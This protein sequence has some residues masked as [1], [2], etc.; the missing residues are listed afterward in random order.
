MK[1]NLNLRLC[2]FAALLAALSIILGKVLA[3]RIGTSIRISFESLP[4]ILSGVFLGPVYGFFSGLVADIIG[5]LI[6]GY[7]I[8]PIITLGCSLMGV[9]PALIMKN[10]GPKFIFLAVPVSH[11]VCSVI[12]KS[13]GLLVYYGGGGA[14]FLSRAIV[15]AITA[16]IEAYIAYF[17]IKNIGKRLKNDLR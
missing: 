12:I 11:I 9:I 2:I 10:R 15:Y 17:L 4:I 14:L 3:F 5:C 8:N 7:E 13:I 1:K 16:P 6:V